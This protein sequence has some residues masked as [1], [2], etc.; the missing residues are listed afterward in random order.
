LDLSY[1]KGL[2]TYAIKREMIKQC[3]AG[4]WWIMW[5]GGGGR[6][7]CRSWPDTLVLYGMDHDSQLMPDAFWNWS[8]VARE[9]A[10]E[11]WSYCA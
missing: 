5:S 9:W 3:M 1:K 8:V 10:L 4:R 6:A 2:L 11:D 7:E